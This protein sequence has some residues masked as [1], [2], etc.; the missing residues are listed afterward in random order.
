MNSITQQLEEIIMKEQADKLVPFLRDLPAG[1]TDELRKKIK[2]LTKQIATYT[3]LNPLNWGRRGTNKQIELA[4]LAGLALLSKQDLLSSRNDSIQLLRTATFASEHQWSHK[5]SLWDVILEILQWRKADWL[6]EC[7]M[8]HQDKNEWFQVS[9]EHLRQLLDLG[10]IEHNKKL[11]VRPMVNWLTVHYNQKDIPNYYAHIKVDDF[12]REKDLFSVFEYDTNI[13]W[14]NHYVRDGVKPVSWQDIFVRLVEEQVISREKVLGK[15]LAAL[16][17]DFNKNLLAWFRDLFIQLK[18][19]VKDKINF[20]HDLF[21]LCNCTNPLPVNFAIDQIK[22]VYPHDDFDVAAFLTTTEGVLSRSDVKTSVKT[23]LGIGEKIARMQPE[24]AAQIS[25]LATNTFL[26]NDTAI[27]EK[28]AKLIQTFGDTADEALTSHIAMFAASLPATVREK[29]STFIY[30]SADEMVQ[31]TE[32][33]V[34]EPTPAPVILDE[35][36][37]L[38][39]LATWNDL[40]FHIGKTRSSLAVTDLELLLDG[41]IRLQDQFPADYAAQLKPYVPK[42]IQ[43]LWGISGLLTGLVADWAGGNAEKHTEKIKI[44]AQYKFLSFFKYRF[45][46]VLHKLQHGQ[47]L[48]LL[49]TPTHAPYWIEAETLVDRISVYQQSQ[50]DINYM[51]LSLALARTLPGNRQAAL[52]KAE[53]L[54]GFYKDLL[55]FFLTDRQSLNAQIADAP[56][57]TALFQKLTENLKWLFEKKYTQ[58]PKESEKQLALWAVAARTKAPQASFDDLKDTIFG[59]VANVAEPFEL[60]WEV[61]R[62]TERYKYA[63]QPNE[64]VY[65]FDELNLQLAPDIPVPLG[66]FYSHAVF[67]KSN[68]SYEYFVPTDMELYESLVPQYAEPFYTKLLTHYCLSSDIKDQ[69]FSEGLRTL[70]PAYRSFGTAALLF[71]ASGLVNGAAVNRGIAVEVLIQTISDCRLPAVQLGECLGKFL[72]GNYAPAQRL[73]DSLTQIKGISALHESALVQILENLLPQIT[74]EPPKNFKKLLELYADLC[75]KYSLA[76]PDS[77][78]QRAQTWQK[79]ATLK[80]AIGQLV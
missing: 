2:S 65:H 40:L 70:L 14:V 19:T 51:D 35:T 20:Q 54:E 1:H 80:K 62:R 34:Y 11:F 38:T 66:M 3:Q 29:L 74:D 5:R 8:H 32:T 67:A 21:E 50:T 33:Y 43:W 68:R 69:T 45:M 36:N 77:V 12:I 48:P 17:H 18:P 59:Q 61:K 15:C 27:H 72:A 31:E 64:Q 53:Q 42:N 4:Q 23:L 41:M 7:L 44:E 13:H 6:T 26:I 10:L 39:P 24:Y 55:L 71:L 22:N 79:S 49:S 78:K 30:V 37:R 52:E 16:K 56:K 75:S 76:A 63:W 73:V 25:Q 46:Y 58:T 47:T 9:Y 60:Q 28:A 57:S